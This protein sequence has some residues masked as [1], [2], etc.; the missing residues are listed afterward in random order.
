MLDQCETTL[1]VKHLKVANLFSKI[2]FG[3]IFQGETSKNYFNSES[4]SLTPD[5][6]A[7]KVLTGL[8]FYQ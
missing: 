2:Y 6:L 8:C 1:I 3:K 4:M 7:L 5:L